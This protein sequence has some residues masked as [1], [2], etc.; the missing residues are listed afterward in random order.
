MKLSQVN[1]EKLLALSWEEKW[2]FVCG[3]AKDEG[4]SG[5]V[6]ILLGSYPADSVLRAEAAA[7]LYLAGRVKYVIPSGGLKWEYLGESISEAQLMKRTLMEK[8]VPEEVIFTDELART[9]VENMI[10]S[11]LVIARTVKIRSIKRALIVTSQFHM[12]RSLALAKALLPRSI[13]IAGFPA[14]PKESKEEWLQ[15]E[16]NRKR[17]DQAITAL[18]RLIHNGVVEDT[19]VEI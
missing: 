19:D 13:E 16:K 6:A 17:L 5:E 2:N 14:L 8:G 9:T 11:T 4:L 10:G 15:K 18:K 3:G 12:Q 7:E 1:L